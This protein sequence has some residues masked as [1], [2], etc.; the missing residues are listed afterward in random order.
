MASV[1]ECSAHTVTYLRPSIPEVED[2]LDTLRKSDSKFGGPAGRDE[3]WPINAEVGLE[4]RDWANRHLQTQPWFTRIVSHNE[5]S[6]FCSF[7]IVSKTR[8]VDLGTCL[9]SMHSQT[10]AKEAIGDFAGV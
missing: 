3:H 4:R 2:V 10:L 6:N 9:G 1:Y 7:S 8:A 5:K